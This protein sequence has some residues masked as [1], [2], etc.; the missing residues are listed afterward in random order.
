MS[1]KLIRNLLYLAGSINIS[2]TLIFSKFFTNTTLIETDPI[3]MSKF[4]LITIIVWGLAFIATA[5]HF[6]KN[7]WIIGVFCLEKTA[8]ITAWVIWFVNTEHTINNIFEKDILAGSFYA[9]YGLNDFL[10]LLFFTYVFFRK[11]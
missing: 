7:K 4:G 10:F 9:L 2:G 6:D 5:N 1:N 8:Y 3:V 11:N